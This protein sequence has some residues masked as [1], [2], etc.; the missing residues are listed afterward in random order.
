[1]NKIVEDLIAL[2]EEQEKRMN[3]QEKRIV[4]LEKLVQ[5]LIVK[6]EKTSSSI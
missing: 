1:M 6:Q 4:E 3:G 5:S 2:V